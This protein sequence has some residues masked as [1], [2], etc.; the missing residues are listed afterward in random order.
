L[1]SFNGMN[2]HQLVSH[3][4]FSPQRRTVASC[5]LLQG[6]PEIYNRDP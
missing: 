4:A 2:E 1:L 5:V 3:L 6:S